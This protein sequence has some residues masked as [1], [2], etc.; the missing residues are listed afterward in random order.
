LNQAD[1]KKTSEPTVLEMSKLAKV[2]PLVLE[3]KLNS[4]KVAEKKL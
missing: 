3:E 4:E 2:P 1:N